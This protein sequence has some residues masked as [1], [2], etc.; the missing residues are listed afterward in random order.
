MKFRI[1]RALALL[2]V[3]GLI[4]SLA[5]CGSNNKT[6]NQ[7]EA[8]RSSEQIN[9]AASTDGAADV[10]TVVFGIRQDL[11]PNSYVDEDGNPAGQNI[12]IYQL[13]DELLPQYE[14]AYDAVDAEAIL[15]GVDSGKYV[16]GLANYFWTEER[17]EK[18]LFPENNVSAGVLGFVTTADHADLTSYDDVAAQGLTMTPKG[19]SDAV[20]A[21]ILEYNEEHPDSPVNCET[22]SSPLAVG[23]AMKQ[24]MEGR[25]DLVV[26]L[27]S[28][29]ESVKDEVDPNG[30][31]L[32]IPFTTI[33]TWVLFGKGQEELVAAVDEAMEVLKEN[34]SLSEISIKYN[35]EDVYAY[36]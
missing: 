36:D 6:G 29:Y 19:A 22:T 13:I 1:K 14:F 8:D 5:G 11:R 26:C 24:V 35:G 21:T 30:E 15:L 9:D 23:E 17:E 33:K 2:L 10:Q 31:L 28:N 16:G 12:E 18:Y 32:F 27:K 3:L 20:Y 4:A 7:N 34:G 25:Y